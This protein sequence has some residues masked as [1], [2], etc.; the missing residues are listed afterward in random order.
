MTRRFVVYTDGASRGNPGPASIGAAIYFDGP[1]G[2]EEIASVSEPVGVTTNNV[3][4]YKAVVAGLELVAEFE[5]DEVLVRA[6]S[7]LLVRQL[8]GRYRVKSQNLKPLYAEVRRLVDRLPRVRFEHVR[9]ESNRRAD[10][11]ANE[12]LDRS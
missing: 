9:R 8:D 4:E 11:L 3:A 2:L 12:A 7:Q 5:P 6:D 10:G 1:E